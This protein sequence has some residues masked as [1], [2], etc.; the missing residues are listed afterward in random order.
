M[1]AL[2]DG[3]PGGV[4]VAG[5]FGVAGEGAADDEAILRAGE[6]DIEQAAVFAQCAGFGKGA[7]AAR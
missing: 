5:A 2:G 7:E 1:A 3:V 6:G 4:G